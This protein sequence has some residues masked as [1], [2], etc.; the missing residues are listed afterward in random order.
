MEAHNLKVAIVS[1]WHPGTGRSGGAVTDAMAYRGGDGLPRLPGRHL[2]GLLREA[3][4]RAEDWSWSGFE[5]LAS[6]LFGDRTEA[7]DRGT[8]FPWP[9]CLRVGDATLS[10]EVAAW[11]GHADQAATRSS[12]FRTVHATAIDHFTGTAAEKSLRGIEVVVPLDLTAPISVIER[13]DSPPSDWAERLAEVLPLIVAVGAHR[14]RGLG[15]A[16]LSW[17]MAQ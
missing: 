14:S 6:R 3:L 16:T 5:G 12:L 10:A 1:Y 15:R 2:K 8:Q 7:D 13:A 11:L 17:E 9:G 4:E